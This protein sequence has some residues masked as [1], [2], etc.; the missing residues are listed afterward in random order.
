MPAP[1]SHTLRIAGLRTDVFSPLPLSYEDGAD[2]YQE[3]RGFDRSSSAADLRI[4]LRDHAA[5]PLPD[6]REVFRCNAWKMLHAGD[7]RRV[8][9]TAGPDRPPLWVADTGEDFGDVTLWREPAG[10][11]SRRNPVCYPLDQILLVHHLASRQGVLVHSAGAVVDGRAY[12]LAGRSGAGKSTISRLISGD[13][14]IRMLSDDRVVI[15]RGEGVDAAWGTPWPGEAGIALNESA[16]LGGLLF[17]EKSERNTIESISS[18]EALTR[19]LPTA[20]VPWYDT[21]LMTGLLDYCGSMAKA[22]RCAVLE[23]RKDGHLAD[24]LVDWANA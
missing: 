18:A 17:L 10:E 24:L 15:R 9:R 12:I 13:P 20:S 7:R 22:A 6:H 1:W 14:R 4:N 11:S 16:P 5:P 8:I 19:L 23:F 3:F 21:S 2:A